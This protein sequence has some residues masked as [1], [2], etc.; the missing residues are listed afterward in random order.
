MLQGHDM[1]FPV[2][3]GGNLGETNVLQ[4]FYKAKDQY[5]LKQGPVLIGWATCTMVTLPS[6][7]YPME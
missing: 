4:A 1:C 6:H 2:P 5:S 7:E 3:P